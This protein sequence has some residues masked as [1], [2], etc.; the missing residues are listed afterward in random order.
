M[1]KRDDFIKKLVDTYGED[2]L[3][4]QKG[5]PT[6]HP[7]STEEA[8]GAMK[9]ANESGQKLFITGF[10]N[11]IDPD[12]EKFENLVIIRTDRLN[13]LLEIVPQDYFIIVGAGYPLREINVNLAKHHLFLPHS[14]LPYVGSVGGALAVGLSC[15]YQMHDLPISRYFIKAEI[16]TPEGEVIVPGS[17]C[18]KSVSGFDIVKIYSPSWGQ[19]GLITKAWFRVM[20][21]SEAY[22]YD[23]IVQKPVDYS[24]FA[25]LYQNPGDNVSAQYSLKIKQKF[26]PN[27]VLPLISPKL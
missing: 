6:F 7:E 9:L 13:Q 25:T 12:G 14:N 10:G 16:A 3:T 4:Y 23:S 18:F 22:M 19:L 24:K 15:E 21:T 20:P 27:G 1:T 17:A 8:A 11:N 2:R 5:L 26:D